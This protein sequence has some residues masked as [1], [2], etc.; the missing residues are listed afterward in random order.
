MRATVKRESR[1]S[2]TLKNHVQRR[3]TCQHTFLVE[4]RDK[5]LKLCSLILG[6]AAGRDSG[7]KRIWGNG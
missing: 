2:G 6:Q 1:E 5:L 7:D 3:K 4:F